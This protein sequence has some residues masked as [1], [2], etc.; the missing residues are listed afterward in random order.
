[1]TFK[2]WGTEDITRLNAGEKNNITA[3]PNGGYVVSW[4]EKNK[5]HFQRY[6]GAGSK[7]GGAQ[8]VEMAGGNQV[9][10]DIQ[11]YG[12]GGD[13]VV[14]WNESSGSSNGWSIKS[15]I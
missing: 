5:A 15:R 6:D 7:V 1:M 14:S 11:A 2:I 12:T 9:V 10:T 13:F 3:L 4:T 8:A